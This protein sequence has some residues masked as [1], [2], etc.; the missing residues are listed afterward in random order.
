VS[1][2]LLVVAIGAL[3]TFV[4]ACARPLSLD[5]RRLSAR[6][7]ASFGISLP[8]SLS[9]CDSHLD[10]GTVGGLIVGA[11]GDSL[12]WAFG[13]RER[14][15]EIP[16]SIKHDKVRVEAWMD[17]LHKNPPTFAYVGAD[18]WSRPRGRLLP[19]GSSAESLFIQLWYVA[20]ADT[21]V[22]GRVYVA[23][24]RSGQRFRASNVA[25]ALQRQRAGGRPGRYLHELSPSQRAAMSGPRIRHP[26][27]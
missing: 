2:L 27:S 5:E 18:H 24:D 13:R 1:G 4:S 14:P 25:R 16:E 20:G 23:P 26:R 22:P 10:G 7:Q 15:I 11:E 17:S 8:C 9:W 12:K 19:V 3:V 21:V 6:L